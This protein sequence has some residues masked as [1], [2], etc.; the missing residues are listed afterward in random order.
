MENIFINPTLLLNNYMKIIPIQL[1]KELKNS[2]YKI[3]F[4][5]NSPRIIKN[6][7]KS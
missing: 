5:N 7:K 4:N 6:L 1:L 3:I 2:G